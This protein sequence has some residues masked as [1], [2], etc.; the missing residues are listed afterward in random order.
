MHAAN[1]LLGVDV[2]ELIERERINGNVL[3]MLVLSCPWFRVTL[4]GV[5][6]HCDLAAATYM[7]IARKLAEWLMIL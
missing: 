6:A 2:P 3:V 7:K 5:Y 1:E 4:G